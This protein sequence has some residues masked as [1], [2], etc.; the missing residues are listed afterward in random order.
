MVHI[1]LNNLVRN[2]ADVVLSL[3]T[4]FGET[5]WWGKAPY[6]RS[7]N[8]QRHIQVDIDEEILGLNKPADVLIQA[9]AACFLEALLDE[10]KQRDL[11]AM[12]AKQDAWLAEIAAARSAARAELDAALA[13][14]DRPLRSPDVP[15]ICQRVFDEDAFLVV[16]GGNTAIWANCYHEVRRPF[17]LLSTFKFGMLGAGVG[18]ALGVRVAFPDRQVYCIIGDGAMGFHPQEI[19]TAIRNDLPV[20][21][22]VLCDRQWGMVKLTQQM[23]FQP[24]ETLLRKPVGPEATINADLGEIRF[25][26]L[27]RSMGAHGE[28]VSHSSELE[29]ALRRCIESGRCSVIHADV[30]PAEHLFAPG[31][32]HFKAMHSEPEG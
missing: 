32:I 7:P 4:R 14:E 16:D 17:S 12:R 15:V 31:L 27:A 10:L 24:E 9:D 18:Q 3:G 30:D 6:W 22:V 23:A 8:E 29:P 2:Q 19:E 13:D 28:R 25:D 1:E 26:D 21:Y 5:D 20:I 11:A